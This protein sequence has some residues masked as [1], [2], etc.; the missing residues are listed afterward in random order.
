MAKIVI[1][2]S[3]ELRHTFFRKYLALQDEVAVL[4]S[5]CESTEKNLINQIGQ[6]EQE[7]IRHQH[8]LSRTQTEEDFFA[9]FVQHSP[10]NSN[11][12]TISRGAINQEAYIQEIIDLDPDL[13][14]AFGCSIIK[15]PLI[16]AFPE[17][18]LNIHLGLSPYYRGSGTNYW[19]FVNGEPEY[20]GVTFM[21]IDAGIDTGEILH[22]IRPDIIQSDNFY[23]ICNRLLIK[24]ASVCAQLIGCFKDLRAMDQIPVPKEA[25]LYKNADFTEESVHQ[26]WQNFEQGMIRNYLDQQADR[27]LQAP[28]ISNTALD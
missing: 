27:A 12:V 5:Y 20:C 11:P 2:T 4:R 23:V 3:S 22:Q 16:E 15:P 25:R 13:V 19:P 17:R 1:L 10:E 24:M 7:Q 26:L 9:L 14:V 21:K 28:I 18:F 8:L 6:S